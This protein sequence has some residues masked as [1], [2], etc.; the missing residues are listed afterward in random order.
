M[1][2]WP[3][4]AVVGPGA[5]GSFFGGMLARAGARVVFVGRPGSKSAHLESVRDR[6]LVFDGVTVKETIDVEVAET[7]E[8]LAAAELVLFCVKTLD[9]ESAAEGIRPYLAQGAAV[10]SLQNGVDN[11]DRMKTIGVEAIPAVVIVA[12]AIDRPGTIRHR[13]RGD[14]IIGDPERPEDVHRIAE[15]FDRAGVP[16]Q[17]SDTIRHELWFKLIIN[18]M[19]NATGALTRASYRRLSEFEPTWRI[20]MAVAREA[21]EVA[22]A[23]GIELDAEELAARG[24]AIIEG[25]GDA[26]S[27]TE[28]DIAHGRRTEIDSL[29][30]YIARRGAELGVRTPTNETLWA[31]VKLREETKA[32]Q[33]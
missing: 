6:G 17:V 3:R 20:A 13:G 9:T 26:T 23:E 19:A 15:I 11:V 28:Q 12:A 10:L 27:S 16:C 7:P 24:A 18:S 25:V 31:L 30:G 14:L 8:A 1:E 21:V 32:T 33:E 4:V 22:R 5:I 29:N 2:A